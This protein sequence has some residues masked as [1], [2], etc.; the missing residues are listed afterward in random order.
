MRLV[1]V[2]AGI[3]GSGKSTLCKRLVNDYVSKGFSVEVC[4]ADDFFMK[5]GTYQFDFKL[6]GSAH[7]MCQGL[8]KGAL[9][10][11]TDIVIV[12]NTNVRSQDRKFYCKL[13]ESYSYTTVLEVLRGDVDICEQRNVH[14]VPREAIERMNTTLTLKPGKYIVTYDPTTDT[15]SED[16]VLIN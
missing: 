12:D 10:R 5:S 13:A 2:L 6:L 4:S 11:N 3:P 1:I 8:F 15:V 9:E 16:L 7:K 14:S